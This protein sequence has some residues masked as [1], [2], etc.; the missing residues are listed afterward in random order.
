MSCP[1]ETSKYGHVHC[2][3]LHLPT[4]E[5]RS[6]RGTETPDATNVGEVD[7][8]PEKHRSAFRQFSVVVSY[9]T[10]EVGFESFRELVDELF[11]ATETGGF[12]DFV[13]VVSEIGVAKCDVLAY[14]RMR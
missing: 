6:L 5:A 13:V 1:R 14:L 8:T 9:G 10:V 11:G 7:G 2:K 3:A 12:A 4:T